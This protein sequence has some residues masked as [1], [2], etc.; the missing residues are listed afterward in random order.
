MKIR[1]SLKFIIQDYFDFNLTFQTCFHYYYIHLKSFEYILY[2]IFIYFFQIISKYFSNKG[3]I[4]NIN[5][6]NNLKK[7][8]AK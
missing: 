5:K 1:L 2:L 6:Y 3:V 4:I 8:K 7:T